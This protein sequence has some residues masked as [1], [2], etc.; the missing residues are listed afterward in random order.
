MIIFKKI[1][2]AFLILFII[3]LIGFIGIIIYAVIS[4]YKPA[5]KESVAVNENP[6][7]LSDSA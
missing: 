3:V 7:I 4:D 6:V 1:L 2:K 5:E